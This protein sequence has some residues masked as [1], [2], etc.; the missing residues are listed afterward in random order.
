VAPA[1]VPVKDILCGVEKAIGVLPEEIVEEIRQETVRILKGSHKPKINLTGAERRALQALKTN[2]A[3]TIL[4]ADKGNET[5]VLGTSDYKWKMAALLV[6]KAYKKLKDPTESVERKSVLLLKKSPIGVEVCQQLC[7]QGSRPPRLY[8]LPKIYKPDVP[9]RSIVSIIGSPTYR[10]DKHL[11]GL[12]STHT[13]NSP[14]HVRNSVESVRTLSSFQVGPHDIMV[15]FNVVSLFTRVPIKDTMDLLEQHF[16]NVLRLFCHVLTTSYFSFNGQ[17]YEQLDGVAMGSPLS[18]VI[19]NFYMEDSVAFLPYVGTIFNRISR[20]LAWH[21]IK[22]VGL[23]SKIVSGFLWLV[24]DNLGL[25][26]PG[27]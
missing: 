15:S 19:A 21:N 23:P 10:L 14:H 13:G 1:S 4:L 3:L 6:D 22:S 2:E 26:T 7:P 18:P 8:G 11:A 20:V 12:L 16:E 9:L 25:R 5:V 27:V 24:K 17:F